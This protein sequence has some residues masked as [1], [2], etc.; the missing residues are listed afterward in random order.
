MNN[1]TIVYRYIP[2]V[3]YSVDLRPGSGDVGSEEKD[4]IF[5][6]NIN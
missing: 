4:T 5:A 2:S 6:N 1:N 3:K